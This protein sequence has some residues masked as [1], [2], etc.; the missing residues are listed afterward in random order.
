MLFNKNNKGSE[1]LYEISGIFQS[2]TDYRSIASEIDAATA[3]VASIVGKAVV[4]EAEAAY[5]L[6]NPSESQAALLLAIQRPVAYLA[7]SMHAKLSGVSHGETG[8]KMKVDENE[9][10]PFEWMLDRD[11]RELRERYY[12]AL[13][14]L[15]R[16]LE[17]TANE[18]WRESRTHK[19]TSGSIVASL[20]DVEG[21]YP[22]EHSYYMFF[23]LLPVFLEIQEFKLRKIVGEDTYALILQKDASVAAVTRQAMRFIVLKSMIV[24]VQRWSIDSFPLSI[25]RR[26]SPSYQGN[27]ERR[28]ATAEEIDWYVNKLELQAQ[29]VAL[30]LQISG[31]TDPYEELSLIPENDPRKKYFTT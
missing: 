31:G 12:R 4:E 13:D 8:R 19:M 7:I 3:E 11:D 30:E 24:A 14:A 16:Y 18:S 25:A 23:K 10:I 17:D 5:E 1:E 22:I 6:P 2:S 21:V 28:A 29:D 9:K 26:F 15:F 20:A 27:H